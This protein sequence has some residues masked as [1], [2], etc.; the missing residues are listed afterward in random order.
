ML[1]VD[2]DAADDDAPAE[3]GDVEATPVPPDTTVAVLVVALGAP[4]DDADPAPD[5]G[6][7]DPDVGAPRAV[8]LTAPGPGVC[9]ARTSPKVAAAPVARMATDLD[10]HRT[11]VIADCRRPIPPGSAGTARLSRLSAG[12]ASPPILLMACSLLSVLVQDS[13]RWCASI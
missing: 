8:A 4:V 6:T 9:L 5:T 10:T 3:L 7:A 12:P 11:R 2:D 1:P 13:P